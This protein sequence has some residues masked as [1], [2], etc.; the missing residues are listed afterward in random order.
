MGLMGGRPCF[1][2]L[3]DSNEGTQPAT[4]FG[5]SLTNGVS[6]KGTAVTVL[7][8]GANTD[9]SYGI[10][11]NANSLGVSNARSSCVLDILADPSGGS[12][13]TT[14]LISNLAVTAASAYDVGAGGCWYYFPIFIKAGTTL[15]ASGCSWNGSDTVRVNYIL[16][17]QPKY[18]HF[19]KCGQLVTTYGITDPNNPSGTAITPG[20]TSEGSWTALASGI[21]ESPWFWN[22]G[23]LLTTSTYASLSYTI[24]LSFGDASN[25]FVVIENGVIGTATTEE[26]HRGLYLPQGYGEAKAADNVYARAQCSG[27]ADTTFEL[28]AYGVSG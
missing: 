21:A 25:K 8:S 28:C 10:F 13:L 5:V 18:P 23:F 16:Q 11:I 26:S 6:G 17:C 20:T 27:T 2:K 3:I 12:T 9:D 7:S 19:V 15:G 14:V 24:D 1:Q 22:M 4:N